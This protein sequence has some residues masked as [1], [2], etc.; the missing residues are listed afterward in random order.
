MIGKKL[1]A[2]DM[3][4]LSQVFLAQFSKYLA[5]S[6]TYGTWSDKG[7]MLIVS[8]NSEN[9]YGITISIT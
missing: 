1:E 7:Q 6:A 5:E 3:N 2:E 4:Y 8:L 9:D